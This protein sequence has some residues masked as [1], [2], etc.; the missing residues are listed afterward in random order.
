M[1]SFSSRG[2]FRNMERFLKNVQ[3]LDIMNILDTAG[4]EGVAALSAATPRDSGLASS[5]WGYE[6]IKTR[7][8]VSVVWTNSDIEDGFPVVIRLQY[9]YGTGTGGYVQGQNFIN[10]AIRP[11]FERISDRI[12][13]AVRVA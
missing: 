10:P 2:S 6:I 7:T 5:S 1:I 11:I 12:G 8:G 13:K 9:G 3:K 4:K